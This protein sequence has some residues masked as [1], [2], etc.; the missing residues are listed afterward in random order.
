MAGEV[1]ANRHL[2]FRPSEAMR[3]AHIAVWTRPKRRVN[4]AVCEH[5]NLMRRLG[6]NAPG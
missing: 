3:L 5:E 1:S 2:R 4:P 6:Q